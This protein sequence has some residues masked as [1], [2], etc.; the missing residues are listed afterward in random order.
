MATESVLI[1]GCSAGGI[2]AALCHEFQRRGLHVFATARTPTKVGD[3]Q[4]LP[5]VTTL[6]L[7]VTSATSIADAVKAVQGQTGGRLKYLVNNSGALYVVPTLDMDIEQAKKMYD[8][9]VW[10]VV[11][12]IQAF[13]PLVIAAKGTIVNIASISGY[14]YSP[15][16]GMLLSDYTS[17][18]RKANSSVGAYGGSKA[19]V[20]LIGETL[21]LEL[22]PFD[23]KV[24]T[25][26]TGVVK[27]N[28][29]S[30]SA[31]YDLPA[32]SLYAPIAK[33]IS[34]RANGEEVKD[35][36]P[37]EDFA[38]RLVNDILGG[39]SGMVYRGKMATVAKYI[40]AFLP[41]GILVSQS[42]VLS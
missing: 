13:A 41:A 15:F 35:A 3:L 2:G 40:S 42:C 39:A 10:G 32:G 18:D 5:A 4:T 26:V 17:N 23:V 38:K 33:Y 31:K 14:V 30:N 12:M 36:G 25:C 37:P 27:T 6:A 16:M 1:T 8:V 28:M 11:A 22:A 20:E 7:D 34:A 29:M 19:A 21:R 24:I 9:N